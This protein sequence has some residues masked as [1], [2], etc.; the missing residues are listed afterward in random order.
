MSQWTAPSGRRLLFALVRSSGL[1]G[2]G[3]VFLPN[4]VA[5]PGVAQ[6]RSVSCGNL[7]SKRA[8]APYLLKERSVHSLRKPECDAGSIREAHF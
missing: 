1:S 3:V 8:L 4:T 2:M 7:I 5:P 6:I